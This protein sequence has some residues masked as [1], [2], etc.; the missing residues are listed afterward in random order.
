GVIGLQPIERRGRIGKLALATIEIALAAPDAA[1][2]EAQGREAAMHEGVVE[3]V[4]HLVIHRAA[5]LRMG[6]QQQRDRRIGLACR[7]ITAFEA[8][9]GAVDNHLGHALNPDWITGL[10]PELCCINHRPKL[11]RFSGASYILSNA[12]AWEAPG[13]SCES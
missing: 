8:P 10:P 7:V 5:M 1:E 4:D 13:V 11:D 3:G 9:D 2:I 12:L 6:M